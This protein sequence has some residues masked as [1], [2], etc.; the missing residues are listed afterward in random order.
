MNC[1][2]IHTEKIKGKFKDINTGK[3]YK[4]KDCI[5][6]E[7]DDAA[8]QEKGITTKEEFSKAENFRDIK[9][10]LIKIKK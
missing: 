10:D 6:W 1:N 7:I 9:I 8:C 4:G 3:I 2:G 5:A